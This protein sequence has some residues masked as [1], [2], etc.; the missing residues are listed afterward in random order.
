LLGDPSAVYVAG[1]AAAVF[2]IAEMVGGS[3]VGFFANR[4]NS[5]TSVLLLNVG[6][7]GIGL[8]LVGAADL[9]PTPAGFWVAVALLTMVAMLGAVAPPLRPAYLTA[10]LPSRQR[11][12]ALSFSSLLGSAGG[13]V[14]QPAPGRVAAVWS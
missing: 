5:R 4:F 7:A 2:A 3:R 8:V 6:V 9:L 12:T 10:V 13:A 1:I 14:A 11:A